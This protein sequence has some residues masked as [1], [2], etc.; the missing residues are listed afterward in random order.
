MIERLQTKIRL[1]TIFENNQINDI[2]FN[3]Q[4]T[5]FFPFI[6][7]VNYHDVLPSESRNFEKQLLFYK[8][9]FQPV[10]YD[11]LIA[12]FDGFW[13]HEKPGLILSFDDG[14][15]SAAEVIAPLLEKHGFQGWFFIPAG[16]LD[17]PDHEQHR[18]SDYKWT[19]EQVFKEYNDMRFYL[20]WPQVKALDKRHVVGCHTLSHCRLRADLSEASL[21]KEIVDAK[22]FLSSR[23]GHEVD[24]FAWVGGE[25][26][27]YSREAA[28]FIQKAGFRFVFLT[29]SSI[30]KPETPP[31]LLDRINIESCYPLSLTKFQIS[32]L[33]D[34]YYTPKRIRVNRRIH[35]GQDK[36]I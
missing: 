3:L 17:I 27:A 7:A 25:S 18:Y 8:K 9:H 34:L 5:L 35:L 2:A 20:T 6:R 4:K 33:M 13:P 21:Q 32:G 23:L 12:F 28:Y 29:N 26:T 36:R 15:R 10:G 11:D 1:S 16:L 24:T 31:H 19:E 22:T 30:I 14:F